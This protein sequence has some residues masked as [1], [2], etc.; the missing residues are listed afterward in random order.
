MKYIKLYENFNPP[1][2]KEDFKTRMDDNLIK[3]YIGSGD[4]LEQ[5][6]IDRVISLLEENC[7]QF[8]DELKDKYIAP[9][10]RGA[11]KTVNDIE[12]VRTDKFRV[13]KDLDMSISN[14]FNDC[15]RA[16]FGVPIRSQGVFATKSPYVT[17]T[18][19]TTK[20]FFPIGDYRYF[21]NPDVDDLYQFVDENLYAFDIYSEELDDDELDERIYSFVDEIASNY[22]DDQLE[23]VDVQEITFTCNKYYLVDPKYYQAIC[24]YLNK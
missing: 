18:Y 24:D 16:M 17:Q 21:W 11:Y 13:P 19:G 4:A 15:F 22:L 8:L 10:F 1:I 5:A 12:E 2:Q 20:L 6:D 23:K 9:I 3:G 14:T 7:S